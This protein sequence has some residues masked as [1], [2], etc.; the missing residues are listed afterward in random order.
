MSVLN[1][2]LGAGGRA[3][4]EAGM[5]RMTTRIIRA[6]QGAGWQ[7]NLCADEERE[8]IPQRSGFH[9]VVNQAVPSDNCLVLRR[10]GWEPFWRIEV[11][12]DRWDWDA[13]AQSFDAGLIEARRGPQFLNFWRKQVFPHQTV[14]RG[15][16]VFVPLQGKLTQRRHF[17]SASPLDM[18]EQVAARWK[19]TPIAA[20]LHPAEVYSEAELEALD[21][22][23]RRYPNLKLPGGESDKHLLACD[24][25]VTENSSM[26]LKGYLV[27]KPAMLWARIDFHHIAASVPRDGQEQAF[28]A[29]EAGGRV[30]FGR[31]L[32]WYFRQNALSL[33]DKSVDEAILRRLSL[34]GWPI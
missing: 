25:V 6:V 21:A 9:M 33:W 1:F 31:Y 8:L 15:G 34:L 27:E 19:D 23:S 17:Q 32:Y 29:V 11:T 7:V 13:A 22:L 14:T 18:L 4:V 20:T 2:Y 30:E 26:A 10:T 24:L 3:A 12:N 16:G 5:P 28:R